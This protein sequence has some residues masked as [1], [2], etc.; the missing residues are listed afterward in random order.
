MTKKMNPKKVQIG[1]ATEKTSDMVM[2]VK[3]ND[4]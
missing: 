3:V 2:I 1:I 4:W